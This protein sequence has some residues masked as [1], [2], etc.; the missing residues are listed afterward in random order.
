MLCGHSDVVFLW[1]E[2]SLSWRTCY[3]LSSSMLCELWNWAS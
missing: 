1:V 3:L 2:F